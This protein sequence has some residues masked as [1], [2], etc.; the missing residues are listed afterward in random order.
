M[1]SANYY[2]SSFTALIVIFIRYKWVE[3]LDQQDKKTNKLNI[4]ALIV[5]IISCIGMTFVANFQVIE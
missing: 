5:G 4:A 3:S 2:I 1:F